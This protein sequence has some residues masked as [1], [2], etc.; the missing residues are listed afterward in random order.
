[1]YSAVQSN[2]YIL[3]R[4]ANYEGTDGFSKPIHDIEGQDQIGKVLKFQSSSSGIF[5]DRNQILNTFFDTHMGM[6]FFE[7]AGRT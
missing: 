3:R 7:R 4:P 6:N 5:R 2:S 1:M